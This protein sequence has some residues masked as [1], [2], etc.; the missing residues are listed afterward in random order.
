LSESSKGVLL[1]IAT[2]AFWGTVAPIYFK[3][4]DRADPAEVLAHRIVWSVVVLVAIITAWRRWPPL[5]SAAS[6]GRIVRILACSAVAVAINWYTYIWAVTHDRLIEASLGYFINPLVSV[7][8]GFAFLRERLRTI[9]WVSIAL[10][11][12][13]V[14][15]LTIAAGVIPWISLTVAFSF[16]LYGLLRKI[17]GVASLNGLTIETGILLPVAGGYLIY[18]AMA[19]T[20]LFGHTSHAFDLLLIASGPVTAVPLLLFAA[21]VRRLRL[22]TIG[23]LQYISP[24]LQFLIA[25]FLYHEPFDQSRMLAFVLIWIA[26]AIYSA[27]NL[28]GPASLP[29]QYSQSSR[30]S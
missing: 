9:E 4:V 27:S 14:V 24:T 30:P 8:L 7:L 10:A 19:G 28:M 1:G 20:I 2:Y 22:A 15:W 12:A 3:L 29:R 25:V 11:T 17:A 21:A 23:L 26:V 16:G 13:S 5:L 18:R 6:D